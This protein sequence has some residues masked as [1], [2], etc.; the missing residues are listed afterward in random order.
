MVLFY[1][2]KKKTR[3]V[4]QKLQNMSTRKKIRF[5]LNKQSEAKR[6]NN[7]APG[8]TSPRHLL[9]LQLAESWL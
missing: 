1:R 4:C 9:G 8:Q 7:N 2:D 5:N 6:S 3:T